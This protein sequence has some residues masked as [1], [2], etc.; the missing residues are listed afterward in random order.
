MQT[1]AN[2][3][4]ELN[5]VWSWKE[6]PDGGMLTLKAFNDFILGMAKLAENLREKMAGIKGQVS[7]RKQRADN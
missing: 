2:G 4:G 7:A 1:I 5:H 6:L 3:K